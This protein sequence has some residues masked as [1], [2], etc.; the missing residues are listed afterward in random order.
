MRVFCNA[1]MLHLSKSRRTSSVIAVIDVSCPFAQH[2]VEGAQ[3]AYSCQRLMTYGQR[4]KECKRFCGNSRR[5]MLKIRITSG[6]NCR[7]QLTNTQGQ[8]VS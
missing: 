3:S 8:F 2:R 5:R 7:R 6:S 1:C 4:K